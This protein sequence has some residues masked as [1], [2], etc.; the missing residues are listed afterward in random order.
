MLLKHC[1]L[2]VLMV[3][4]QFKLRIKKFQFNHFP[5]RLLSFKFMDKILKFLNSLRQSES[6]SYHLILLGWHH[7]VDINLTVSKH[8][9]ISHVLL[10]SLVFKLDIYHLSLC[11]LVFNEDSLLFFV[12]DS[13]LLHQVLSSSPLVV[14]MLQPSKG[15]VCFKQFSFILMNDLLELFTLSLQL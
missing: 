10:K 13:H 6:I 8:Q 15:S 12:T 7:R 14:L 2:F 3:L 11:V 1:Q 4:F 9:E 5:N